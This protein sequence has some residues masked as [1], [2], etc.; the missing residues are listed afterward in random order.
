MQRSRLIE[1]FSVG[2]ATLVYHFSSP[3]KLNRGVGYVDVVE[4]LLPYRNA[5]NIFLQISKKCFILQ[6][7]K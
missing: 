4:A 1:E 7:I 6:N 5:T 2:R 3:E